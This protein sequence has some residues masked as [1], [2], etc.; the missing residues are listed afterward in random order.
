[1]HPNKEHVIA[2]PHSF[3]INQITIERLLFMFT[4]GWLAR[5]LKP[6]VSEKV[7]IWASQMVGVLMKWYKIE[8]NFIER[9]SVAA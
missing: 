7:L 2:S 4:L 3:Y 9:F 1:M 8:L 6:A 5:E